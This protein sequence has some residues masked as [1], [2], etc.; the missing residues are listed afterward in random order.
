MYDQFIEIFGSYEPIVTTATDG[1]ITTS[2]DFGFIMMVLFSLVLL[3]G[4]LMILRSIIT[5]IFR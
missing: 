2:I 5:S 3:H 4:V 1:S